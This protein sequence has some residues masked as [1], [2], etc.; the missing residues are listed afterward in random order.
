MNREKL[1]MANSI[2]KKMEKCKNELMY[3]QRASGYHNSTF[4]VDLDRAIVPLCN[5]IPFEEMKQR[6]IEHYRTKI[7]ELEK[8]FNNL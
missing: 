6:A 5:F 8:E 3:W 2:A 1:E 4:D 7:A